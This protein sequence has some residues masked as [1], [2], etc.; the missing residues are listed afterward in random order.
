MWL[1]Y[2][3]NVPIGHP[4]VG[5]GDRP[6]LRAGLAGEPDPVAVGRR[7][8][9]H[10]REGGDAGPP[11]V[12]A[13]RTPRPTPRRARRPRPPGRRARTCPRRAAGTG[14]AAP[15]PSSSARSTCAA[16]PRTTAHGPAASLPLT[17]SAAPA[18]SSATRRRGDGE[19]VAV[20]VDAAGVVVEHPRP[21]APIARSVW[22]CRQARP[23]VSVTTTA[24]LRAGAREQRRRAAARALASGSWG[25]STTVPA[26]TLEASIA[27]R[28]HHQAEAVLARSWSGRGGRP[29]G[30]SPS[31]SS[32]L[33]RAR[34]GPGPR[35]C[36]RPCW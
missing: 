29:P 7:G 23:A 31:A 20:A 25:S 35:P 19:R 33:A 21:A 3:G 9:A 24:T 12:R 11:R 6:G 27:G 32:L 13:R 2:G 28:G 18:T 4:A 15:G 16:R 26:S 10:P 22:P 17:R 36:S 34:R 30:R 1:E 8:D 14:C 5:V